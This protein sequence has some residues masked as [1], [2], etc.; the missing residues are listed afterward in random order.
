MGTL[1]SCSLGASNITLCSRQKEGI[2][3]FKERVRIMGTTNYLSNTCFLCKHKI[4]DTYNFFPQRGVLDFDRFKFFCA[5][6]S[7]DSGNDGEEDENS[8]KDSNFVTE[9]IENESKE[10]KSSVSISSGVSDC[11]PVLYYLSLFLSIGLK[12]C[13]E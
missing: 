6:S 12:L 8:S 9:D 1:P 10:E 2:G 5:S 4:F 7:N 3:I 11:Y 13:F